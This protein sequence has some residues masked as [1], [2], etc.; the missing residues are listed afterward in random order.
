VL[1]PAIPPPRMIM[2]CFFCEVAADDDV[3]LLR[4]AI[5]C[6]ADA[7]ASDAAEDRYIILLLFD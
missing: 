6:S 1:K 7:T 2:C 3:K 4:E 5:L